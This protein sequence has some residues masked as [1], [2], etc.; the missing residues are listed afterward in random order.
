MWGDFRKT[1]TISFVTL[2]L[3]SCVCG[4]SMTKG[5]SDPG[6]MNEVSLDNDSLSHTV[7]A[8]R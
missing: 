1:R 8:E 5:L 7:M 2:T 4:V 6:V 3:M